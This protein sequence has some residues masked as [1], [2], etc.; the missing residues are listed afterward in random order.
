MNTTQTYAVFTINDDPAFAE[1]ALTAH[2]VVRHIYQY[3]GGDYRLEPKMIRDRTDE[4]GNELPDIQDAFDD[5]G[6]LV[7]LVFEIW[8]KSCGSFPWDTYGGMAI[9]KTKE[10]AEASFLRKAFDDASWD[11]AYWIVLNTEQYMAEKSRQY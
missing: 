3:D 11:H 7:F 9:G 10:E 4:E 1:T 5:G 8:F 6:D 2:D